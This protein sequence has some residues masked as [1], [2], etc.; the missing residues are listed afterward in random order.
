MFKSKWSQSKLVLATEI[1]MLLTCMWEMFLNYFAR[2]IVNIFHFL[3]QQ[4][5]WLTFSWRRL[6]SWTGFYMIMASVRKGLSYMWSYKFHVCYSHPYISI[7]PKDFGS[8]VT[9][10]WT[11]AKTCISI[12]KIYFRFKVVNLILAIYI[13]FCLVRNKFCCSD[14]IWSPS[15]LLSLTEMF[16]VVFL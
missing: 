5:D 10:F 4:S 8:C 3:L 14:F 9:F 11:K 2:S 13:T 12:N 1:F 16:I 7:S 15:L 6:L